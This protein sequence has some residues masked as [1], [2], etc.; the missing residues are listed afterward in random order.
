MIQRGTGIARREEDKPAPIGFSRGDF[1]SKEEASTGEAQRP[2]FLNAKKEGE[3][4]KNPFGDAKPTTQSTQST[5]PTQPVTQPA[6]ATEDGGWRTATTA[7]K[8]KDD[9]PKSF[10]FTRSTATTGQSTGGAGG[11]GPSKGFGRN[12]DSN[13]SGSTGGGW[14]K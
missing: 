12:T 6:P 11:A 4:K 8:K 2:R 7:P 1:K 14:R 10:G 13:A 9:A 5:Q 3:E